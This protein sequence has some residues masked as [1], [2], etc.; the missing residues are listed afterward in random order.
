MS[1]QRLATELM[2]HII[3]ILGT[4]PREDSL[5]A[6]LACSTANSAL[7]NTSQKHIFHTVVLYS[8]SVD[9]PRWFTPP[10]PEIEVQCDRTELFLRSIADSPRLCSYV[11]ELTC[12]FN[13]GS[14]CDSSL[15][16]TIV[17]D[18]P[19]IVSFGMEIY[20][21]PPKNQ[22]VAGIQMDQDSFNDIVALL[23]Q[24]QLEVLRLEPLA[25]FPLE[26]LYLAPGLKKLVLRNCDPPFLVED[27]EFPTE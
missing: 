5:P 27:Y 15:I 13:N 6:L 3:D 17:C 1:T 23:R 12:R 4:D 10:A 26:A 14:R 25:G 24:P 19:S 16:H 22:P 2:E 7:L 8:H 21:P 20:N 11:K 18:L 9:T